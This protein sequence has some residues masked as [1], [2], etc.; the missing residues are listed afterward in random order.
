MLHL[1]SQIEIDVPAG[2]AFAL[3]CDPVRKS[4]L[5]PQIEAVLMAAVSAGPLDVGSRFHYRLRTAAGLR[6]FN[7]TVTAFEPDRLLEVV[8]DTT[9]PFRVRQTLEPT[10]DGCL[11][12]HDEWIEAGQAQVQAGAQQRPLPFLLRV[13]EAAVGYSMPTPA[14]LDRGQ[15]DILKNELQRALDTWLDRLKACLESAHH[16]LPDSDSAI[17]T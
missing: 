13:L 10:L 16:E 5:N 7:C 3:L 6:A 11:L 1:Q 12:S 4:E 2:Q 9:P 14:E 8:S 17:V 15:H